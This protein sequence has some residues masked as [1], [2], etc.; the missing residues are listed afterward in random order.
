MKTL[1]RYIGREVLA[2]TFLVLMGLI[3]LVC[4]FRPDSGTG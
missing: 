2:S 3:V 1:N 4:I